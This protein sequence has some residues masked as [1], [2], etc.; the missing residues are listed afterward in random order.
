MGKFVLF[1]RIQSL[2]FSDLRS[3]IQRERTYSQST[4]SLLLLEQLSL[5]PCAQNIALRLMSP[6]S[7]L[8]QAAYEIPR[9]QIQGIQ[10]AA[11]PEKKIWEETWLN[12]ARHLGQWDLISEFGRSQNHLRLVLQASWKMGDW[13]RMKE[14]TLKNGNQDSLWSTLYQVCGAVGEGEFFFFFFGFILCI[15]PQSYVC[16]Y[17]SKPM[18]VENRYRSCVQLALKQWN[19]LPSLMPTSVSWG[20]ST[21]RWLQMSSPN[22]HWDLLC[23]FQQVVEIH[24]SAKILK[25]LQGYFIYFFNFF[26][27]SSTPLFFRNE[28]TRSRPSPYR[29]DQ[30]NFQYLERASSQPLGRY[31]PVGRYP[32]LEVED[33][34]DGRCCFAFPP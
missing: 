8:E 1:P 9:E 20:R 28:T 25:E 30:K 19:S 7:S 16:C 18:E 24:D 32:C 22:A 3:G 23:Q 21:Q 31:C 13:G 5:Y 34:Y 4:Y 11:E 2:F 6:S 10:Q 29:R 26:C 17:D 12:C 14:A 15:Y 27:P 33:V